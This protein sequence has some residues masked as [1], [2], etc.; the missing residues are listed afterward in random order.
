M[1]GLSPL[2]RRMIED[3][4]LRCVNWWGFLPAVPIVYP[5]SLKMLVGREGLEPPTRPL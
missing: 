2:R 3:M 4:R 1:A 5:N